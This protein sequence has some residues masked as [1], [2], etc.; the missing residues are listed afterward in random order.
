[1]IKW[2][3]DLMINLC[4]LI[5][6]VQTIVLLM[7]HHREEEIVCDNGLSVKIPEC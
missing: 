5:E 4:D 3:Y 1:M 7:C 2:K 6:S